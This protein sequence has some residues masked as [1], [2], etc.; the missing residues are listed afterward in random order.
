M[1]SSSCYAANGTVTTDA[2][3][4]RSAPATD[5][6]VI[7]KAYTGDVLDVIGTDGSFYIINYN[8]S[9]AYTSRDYVSVDSSSLHP[10]KNTG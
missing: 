9:T 3:N 4:I 8:G 7:A 6:S 5:S 10:P 1:T 2:L